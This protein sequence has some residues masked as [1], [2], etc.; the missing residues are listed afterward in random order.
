MQNCCCD[1]AGSCCFSSNEGMP[2]TMGASRITDWKETLW[3]TCCCRFPMVRE[4][5][6]ENLCCSLVHVC[7]NWFCILSRAQNYPCACLRSW[8]QLPPK[9]QFTSVPH[10]P[11]AFKKRSWNSS[12]L[13]QGRVRSLAMCS[14]HWSLSCPSNRFLDHL[15]WNQFKQHCQAFCARAVVSCLRSAH[16]RRPLWEPPDMSIG[17]RFDVRPPFF[18]LF[19]N[20]V[21]W[22]IMPHGPPHGITNLRKSNRKR[23]LKRSQQNMLNMWWKW[24]PRTFE[25]RV[26]VEWKGCKILL[27]PKARISVRR[28]QN[29]VSK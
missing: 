28:Y 27:K 29:M 11:H 12:G 13:G 24:Y 15:Q 4:L 26:F 23:N 21:F 20:L 3:Q 19:R 7:F 22:R 1:L 10:M 25:K 9:K 18:K 6:L 8:C 2:G 5:H 17:C 14:W 16:A